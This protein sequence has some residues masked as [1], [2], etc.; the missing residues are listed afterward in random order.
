MA[1]EE[2]KGGERRRSLSVCV[3]LHNNSYICNLCMVMNIH[4]RYSYMAAA[5]ILSKV[6]EEEENISLSIY[7]SASISMA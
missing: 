2:G 6:K 4:D 3:V 1:S 7:I 5:M